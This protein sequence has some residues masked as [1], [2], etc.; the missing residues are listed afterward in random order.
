MVILSI[1]IDYLVL[2]MHRP[3]LHVGIVYP[4]GKLL[5]FGK[6]VQNVLSFL[7]NMLQMSI[8]QYILS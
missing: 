5:T 4:P 6:S 3:R 7:Q 2:N 1:N 8:C